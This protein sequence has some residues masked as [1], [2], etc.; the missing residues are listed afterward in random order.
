MKQLSNRFKILLM[1]ACVVGFLLSFGIANN[2]QM[3]TRFNILLHGH[4]AC[5]LVPLTDTKDYPSHA[6]G[7]AV[8]K[9]VYSSRGNTYL[10]CLD[11]YGQFIP[12]DSRE[13]AERRI[14]WATAFLYF[15]K[16]AFGLVFLAT[17]VVVWRNYR[18]TKASRM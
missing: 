13:P 14:M 11:L 3:H 4:L 2:E 17:S 1:A 18:T 7:Q 12:S 6:K 15:S 10:G 16:W 8:S 5:K 9:L